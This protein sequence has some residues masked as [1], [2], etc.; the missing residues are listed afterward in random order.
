MPIDSDRRAR[1]RL[2][3]PVLYPCYN[4]T[5]ISQKVILSLFSTTVKICSCKLWSWAESLVKR[6]NLC[7]VLTCDKRSDGRDD[8]STPSNAAATAK[9]RRS[10]VVVDELASAQYREIARN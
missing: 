9:S 7:A 3:V 2:R 4:T 1:T 5:Q 6:A 8:E 10:D